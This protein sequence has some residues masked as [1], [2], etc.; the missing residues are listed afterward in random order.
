MF[1]DAYKSPSS[2]IIL[3]NVERLLGEFCLAMTST[4]KPYINY[5]FRWLDLILYLAKTL[6]YCTNNKNFW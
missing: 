1:D 2:V 3:D 5:D 4:H 6:Q